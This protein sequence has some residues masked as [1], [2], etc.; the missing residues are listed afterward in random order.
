M[1]RLDQTASLVGWAVIMGIVL[2]ASVAVEIMLACCKR[3]YP[4]YEISNV[5][6]SAGGDAGRD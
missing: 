6:T 2:F 4:D 5:T 1:N 3:G